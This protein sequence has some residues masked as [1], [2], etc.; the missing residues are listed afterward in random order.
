MKKMYYFSI[1]N[2]DYVS[3]E[4]VNQWFSNASMWHLFVK[5][6][7]FLMKV[8]LVLLLERLQFSC[9]TP[10]FFVNDQAFK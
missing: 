5:V 6:M 7:A 3:G 1:Q 10:V 9:T 4:E 2:M 8:Q